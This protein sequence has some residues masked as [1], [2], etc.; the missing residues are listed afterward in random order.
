MV[1]SGQ[2]S[3]RTRHLENRQFAK[4]GWVETDLLEIVRVDTK[5]NTPD[6]LTKSNAKILFHRHNEVLMGK[7]R[8]EYCH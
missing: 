7:H 6:R 4:L 8:P 5:D 2:P 1:T 3:K